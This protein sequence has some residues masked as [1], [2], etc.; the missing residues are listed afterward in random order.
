MIH[1]I[2]AGNLKMKNSLKNKYSIISSAS[3]LGYCYIKN[4]FFSLWK[5]RISR[6]FN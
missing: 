2:T 3:D 5:D 4:I 6:T 1:I